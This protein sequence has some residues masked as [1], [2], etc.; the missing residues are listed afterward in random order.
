MTIET[1]GEIKTHQNITLGGNII[2]S[3]N[4]NRT[5][6]ANV[7]NNSITLGDTSTVRVFGLNV[8]EKIILGVATDSR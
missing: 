8:E 7:R 2:S 6:F 1:N 3:T 4:T 5:I